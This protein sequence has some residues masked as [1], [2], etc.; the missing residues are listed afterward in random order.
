MLGDQRRHGAAAAQ[1]GG[2]RY[3][4][5][6]MRHLVRHDWVQISTSSRSEGNLPTR[7]P[8]LGRTRSTAMPQYTF[9]IDVGA[10]GEPE[11]T[12]EVFEN[13]EVAVHVARRRLGARAAALQVGRGV[14]EAVRWIGVWQGGRRG[15][16]RDVEADLA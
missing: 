5:V 10:A 1:K 14:G 8:Y 2:S 7:E 12:T 16:W 9:R 13:D 11:T 15:E 6:L 3:V 4:I